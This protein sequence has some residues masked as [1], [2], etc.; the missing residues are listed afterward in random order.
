MSEETVLAEVRTEIRYSE[1]TLAW[2]A[3]GPQ[4]GASPQAFGPG[5]WFSDE[6]GFLGEFSSSYQRSIV[7]MAEPRVQEHFAELGLGDPELIK[8]RITGSHEGSLVITAVI[9]VAATLGVAYKLLKGLSELPAMADG[10]NRLRRE[11]LDP[12][13]EDSINEQAADQLG[14]VA[15]RAGFPP[16]PPHPVDVSLSLDTRPLRSLGPGEAAVRRIHLGVAVDDVS[17]SI[18]NLADDAL[19]NLLIGIFVGDQPRDQWGLEDAFRTSVPS[20]GGKQT[21]VRSATDFINDRGASPDLAASRF[22]D[23]WVQDH[24]GIH[25]FQFIRSGGGNP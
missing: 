25:L 4:L 2:I 6:S 15:E 7:E 18:E 8:V 24:G 14:E 5:A 10:L 17:V 20:L 13:M 19:D 12:V 9:V 23:C 3:A 22:I 21:I 11:V 1:E 16:P